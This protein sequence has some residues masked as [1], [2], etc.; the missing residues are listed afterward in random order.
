MGDIGI[1]AIRSGRGFGWKA[2]IRSLRAASAM[3]ELLEGKP[4]VFNPHAIKTKE[5]DEQ[6]IA[7][8]GHKVPK[9]IACAAFPY[10]QPDQWLP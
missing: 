10:L 7:A 6:L 3:D 8:H 5:E 9:E 4:P 1:V 2:Y